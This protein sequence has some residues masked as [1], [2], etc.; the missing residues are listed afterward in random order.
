MQEQRMS[1]RS[2]VKVAAVAGA[3]AV[4]AACQPEV[5]KETVVVEKEKVVTATPVPTKPPE[6]A[7]LDVWCNTDIPDVSVLEGWEA[8]AD[9]EV[10]AKMWYWGGLAREL[11]L[12]WLDK[13]P[14]VSLKITG[15]SW[16]Y[17][18]RQNH[19]M[20]LAAGLVP[21]VTY[22]EGYVSEFV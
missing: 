21:D 6:P 7:V 14:G 11:Y 2:F 5:V 15:H 18:L 10:F 8:N 22:G 16:D 19:L 3:G 13:H 9:N 12:P 1:R 4:L 17:D 20:A